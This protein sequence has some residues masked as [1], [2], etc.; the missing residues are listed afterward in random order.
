MFIKLNLCDPP[1]KIKIW[2]YNHTHPPKPFYLKN[3]SGTFNLYL[4][5]TV[6]PCASGLDKIPEFVEWIA[7]VSELTY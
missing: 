6:N 3:N 7:P 5:D 1:V 4:K 2:F